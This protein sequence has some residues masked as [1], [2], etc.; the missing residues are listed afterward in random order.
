[1]R[2]STAV[3]ST[4]RVQSW[5]SLRL[6]CTAEQPKVAKH[7]LLPHGQFTGRNFETLRP[8]H[9]KREN[10][11]KQWPSLGMAPSFLGEALF[12]ACS[13]ETGKKTQ[14]AFSRVPNICSQ[15]HIAYNTHSS[16]TTL[17]QL[18]CEKS[19]K[20][21]A[22]NNLRLGCKLE[23]W[24]PCRDPLPRSSWR[25]NRWSRCRDRRDPLRHALAR[26]HRGAR[27]GRTVRSASKATRAAR[28][29]TECHQVLSTLCKKSW[30]IQCPCSLAW[31]SSDPCTL[32]SRGLQPRC[33]RRLHSS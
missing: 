12:R 21:T 17:G 15:L 33:G 18:D 27:G 7:K 1:M 30:Y 3:A 16:N 9:R 28:R 23:G 24:Q 29:W 6:N 13:K 4:D 25:P 14:H 26:R 11:G 31:L 8:N 19:T 10:W 5:H 22:A 20:T 32:Q 2:A